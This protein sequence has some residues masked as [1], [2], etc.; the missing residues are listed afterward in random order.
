MIS[1]GL[2]EL[3]GYFLLQR[4]RVPSKVSVATSIFVVALTA[5]SASPKPVTRY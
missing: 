3:N 4:C 2:G 5:L 1:T